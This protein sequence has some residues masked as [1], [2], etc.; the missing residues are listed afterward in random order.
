M[1]QVLTLFKLEFALKFAK[2]D[3]KK[4]IFVKV[5]DAI[6]IIIGLAAVAGLVMFMFNSIINV[7][8]ESDLADE[9]LVF[10]LLIVQIIQLFF[11]LGL[12]TKTLF[13]NT[14]SSSLLKL[15]VS[16]EKIFIAKAL[17]AYFYLTFLSTIIILPV[18]IMFGIM[19]ACSALFFVMLP[20][21]CL[22]VPVLPFILAI[23]FAL[24]T[25]Y[26]ISFLKS[27]FLLMLISY[28]LIVALGFVIYMQLLQMILALLNQNDAGTILTL[29]KVTA[30][31]NLA[32]YFY[33]EVLLKNILT[34]SNFAVSLIITI[35]LSASV[36]T[37]LFIL[38]RKIYVNVLLNNV[39]SENTFLHKEIKLKETSVTSA[40]FKREFLNIFRSVNYSFQYLAVVLTTPLMIYF[41]NSIS[42]K[43][44]AEQLGSGLLPGIAILVIIMFLSMAVSFSATS[45]TREGENFFHTKI[46]PVSFKKQVFVKLCLYMIVTIPS[47]LVS[48]L[49][50]YLVG[51]LSLSS[52]FIYTLAI[53]LIMLGNAGYGIEKD[54]KNPKFRYVSNGEM[55]STNR[56]VISS[57]GLGLIIALVLGVSAIIVS[58]I[59]SLN[60]IYYILFGF[61]IPYSVIETFML[62]FHLEKKYSNIEA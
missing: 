23:I 42:A 25:M 62:F 36:L 17:F 46:I 12:L 20:I 55:D 19:N 60:F 13:F 43:I 32:H 58:Y 49:I 39:E 22:L 61:A 18:L 30:V 16:G 6:L 3:K 29:D 56:N 2:T 48:C 5:F 8:I 45:F 34:G 51:T 44:G 24:P 38:A 21:I 53:S 47:I 1:K 40:L 10:F 35:F 57:V 37:L 7:C 4:N 27:R 15:P 26:L 11:G 14:D 59:Y 28:V 31:K 54:L 41:S 9:F 52:M 50:L 33:P